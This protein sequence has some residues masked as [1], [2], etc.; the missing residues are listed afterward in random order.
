MIYRVLYNYRTYRVFL[1]LS[2]HKRIIFFKI[3]FFVILLSRVDL[4]E[5][6]PGFWTKLC[7]V[8]LISTYML[9]VHPIPLALIITLIIFCRNRNILHHHVFSFLILYTNL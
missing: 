2:P 4:Q 7:I 8:I 9:H 1:C 3:S 6:Y 5:L